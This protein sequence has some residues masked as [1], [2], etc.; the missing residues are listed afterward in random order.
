MHDILHRAAEKRDLTAES[1]GMIDGLLDARN[2]RCERSD[3]DPPFSAREDAGEGFADD[4]FGKRVTGASAL[5]ESESMHSTPSSPIRAMR[6]K[7]AG[8]PSIG[9][10][11]E[12]EIAGVKDRSDRR[13]DGQRTR[14]CDRVIDVHELGLDRCRAARGRRA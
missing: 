6:A 9:R 10:L 1:Y 3:Q 2:V 4:A 12:L 11:I 13:A 8:L 7:S 5:V 14:A